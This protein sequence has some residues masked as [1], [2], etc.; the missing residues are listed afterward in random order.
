[1]ALQPVPGNLDGRWPAPIICTEKAMDLEQ[2]ARCDGSRSVSDGVLWASCDPSK[3]SW[4]V[5][6]AEKSTACSRRSCRNAN[7]LLHPR[8]RHT[9]LPEHAQ[10]S[11]ISAHADERTIRKIAEAQVGGVSSEENRLAYER[12]DDPGGLHHHHRDRVH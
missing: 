6:C 10:S 3:T 7:A 11:S 8:T 1:M 5:T 2:L 9:A 4:R 12:G